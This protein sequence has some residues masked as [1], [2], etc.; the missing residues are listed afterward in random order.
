MGLKAVLTSIEEAPEALRGL[1]VEKDGAFILPV[2]G[3]I[4]ETQFNE[5]KTKLSEFRNSNIQVLKERDQLKAQLDGFAKQYEGVDLDEYRTLKEQTKKLKGRGVE[6]PDDIEAIIKKAIKPMADKIESI[7]MERRKLQDALSEKAFDDLLSKSAI[8]SGV[9]LEA[10]EDAIYRAKR[11]FNFSDGKIID[12][13]NEEI[14][15]AEWFKTDL[16]V[17]APHLFKPNTGSGVPATPDGNPPVKT[18]SNIDPVEF[19]KN[20]EG[21]AKGKIRIK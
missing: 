11:N 16:A 15:P 17:K 9:R 2:E 18:L 12:K 6:S 14:S 4:P 5:A 13:N 7:E 21:I 19:G 10:V 8:D 20:L 1:Y 3:M